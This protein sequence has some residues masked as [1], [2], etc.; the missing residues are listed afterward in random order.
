MTRGPDISFRTAT[1]VVLGAALVARLAYW[2][3]AVPDYAPISDDAQYLELA[4]NIVEGNGFS[5]IFPQLEL[6]PTAFRPPLYPYLL[7]GLFLVV[8][9][10]SIAWAQALNVAIGLGVVFLT[11]RVGA[12]LG[13]RRAGIIA[14]LLVALFPPIIANDVVLLTEP[15][16]LL[17]LLGCILA[18]LDGRWLVAGLLIGALVLARPSAQ[19]LVVAIVLWLWLSRRRAAPVLRP[20]LLIVAGTLLVVAPWLVRNRVEMGDATLVTSNGFNVAA[21]YSPQAIETGAFVDPVR[22][23][24]FGDHRFSQLDEIVWQRE[25]QDLAW[26]NVV[27]HPSV[28]VRVAQRNVAAYFELRPSF[29]VKAEELD[30]RNPAVRTWALPLV[31]A[32]LVVGTVGLV[33]LRRTAGGQLLIVLAGY[34]VLSSVFLIA[35]PRVRAPVDLIL[36]LA[37]ATVIADGWRRRLARSPDAATTETD[38]ASP[39]EPLPSSA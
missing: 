7:A 11:I 29:N 26:R 5:L 1:L 3:F 28:L 39:D 31:Y 19:F 15:L 23:E 38:P 18:L 37:T 10:P 6:H 2:R 8:G 21:L 35:V 30:G 13:G 20:V 12:R 24:R 4:T 33:R 16:S 32:N 14:G 9:G 34:F 17:I 25:L 27:D 36:C 22:D